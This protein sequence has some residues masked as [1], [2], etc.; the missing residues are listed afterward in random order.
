MPVGG[1]RHMYRKG[2]S[3]EMPSEPRGGA[4][5]CAVFGIGQARAERP[6]P[7]AP[8]RPHSVNWRIPIALVASEGAAHLSPSQIQASAYPAPPTP[9]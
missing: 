3:A 5:Y 7:H 1:N 4:W 2:S 9:T 8:R 6:G